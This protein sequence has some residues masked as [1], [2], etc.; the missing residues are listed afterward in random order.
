M[1]GEWAYEGRVDSNQ[2][3]ERQV[4]QPAQARRLIEQAVAKEQP[5]FVTLPEIE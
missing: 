4:H 5:A 1:T 2:L 3:A